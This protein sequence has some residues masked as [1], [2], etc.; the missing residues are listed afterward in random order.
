MIMEVRIFALLG[1][2][3][4]PVISF[5]IHLEQRKWYLGAILLEWAVRYSVG[6]ASSEQSS[7]PPF[8]FKI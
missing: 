5:A 3:S 4:T 6:C 1:T 2:S 8:N 7:F